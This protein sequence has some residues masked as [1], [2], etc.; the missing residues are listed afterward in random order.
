VSETIP[1]DIETTGENPISNRIIMIGIGDNIFFSKDEKEVLKDL[2]AFL[3]RKSHKNV[4]ITGWRVTHDI[5][6]CNMRALKYG[7]PLLFERDAF[8]IE[9]LAEFFR[10]DGMPIHASDLADFLGLTKHEEEPS[11][12]PDVYLSLTNDALTVER[13]KKHLRS[14]LEFV[15]QLR[16]RLYACG[17]LKSTKT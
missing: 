7:L 2:Q 6:F 14:H 8:E 10:Y 5:P 4:R 16:D 15:M 9:D 13:I 1:F 11:H 17:W 12:I 3:K